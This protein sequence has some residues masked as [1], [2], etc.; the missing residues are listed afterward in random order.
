MGAG[1][2]R[3]ALRPT[4]RRRVNSATVPDYLVATT[5]GDNG[6]NPV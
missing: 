1:Q 3:Q 5:V 6:E 4:Y 2:V